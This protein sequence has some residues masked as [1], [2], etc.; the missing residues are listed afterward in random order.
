M[1]FLGKLNSVPLDSVDEGG[2]KGTK[3]NS[4]IFNI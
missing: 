2:G 4:I 1:R 3:I